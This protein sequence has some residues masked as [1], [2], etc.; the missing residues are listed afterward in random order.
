MKK[1][2]YVRRQ[3]KPA[4]PNQRK[5]RALAGDLMVE[6][7]LGHWKVKLDAPLCGFTTVEG[8]T[9]AINRT[10]AETACV[11]EAREIFLRRIQGILDGDTQNVEEQVVGPWSAT[12]SLCR[13]VFRRHGEPE[14]GADIRC[15]LCDRPLTFVLVG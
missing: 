8:R 12:C 13:A 4:T 5:I 10:W 7:D 1:S 2:D 15:Q 11:D 14:L 3:H 6:N 9:L